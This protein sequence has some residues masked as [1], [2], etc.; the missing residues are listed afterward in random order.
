MP[1]TI[2]TVKS[3][4]AGSSLELI[5]NTVTEWAVRAQRL[6]LPTFVD[7]FTVIDFLDRPSDDG[8]NGR[9]EEWKVLGTEVVRQLERLQCT[10]FS[11]PHSNKQYENKDRE[12]ANSPSESTS[13]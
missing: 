2:L 5:Q 9:A 8:S 6:G 3:S 1:F 11:L 12:I 4:R 10:Y 13:L 7:F